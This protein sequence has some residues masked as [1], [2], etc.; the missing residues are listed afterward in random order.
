MLVAR[1]YQDVPAGA[2]GG[3]LSIGN[4]DGVHLGHQAVIAQTRARAAA[5]NAPAGVMLFDPHPRAFFKPEPPLFTL[6]PM[7]QRLELLAAL[8]LDFAAVLAFNAALA[9]LPA[10]AFIAQVLVGGFAVRHVVVG[11]DFNFGKGR[12]GNQ[13]L[14]EAEGRRLGFGVTGLDPVADGSAAYSSS[15]IREAL[16]AG[17]VEDA[18]R[19]LGR[20]WRVD[21][22]VISGAGRGAGLGYPT[23][24]IALPP[25]TGLALGI[26]AARVWVDGAA[27]PAV[28]YHGKRPVFDDGKPGFE[29]F[30]INYDSDLYG[31][32]IRIDLVSHIRGD[33]RFDGVEALKSQMDRDV[34]EALARLALDAVRP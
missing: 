9:S 28:A 11:H 20:H 34:A 18:A 5:L 6:T 13:A 30:L 17:K 19:L 24:N 15:R 7:D 4:F 26:Y 27:H 14:L 10:E 8:G 2:R 1:N 32:C 33:R 12:T 22:I 16:A 25:G 21:G 29:T 31:K 3:V 23:A